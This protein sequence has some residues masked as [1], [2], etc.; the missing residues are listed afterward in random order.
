MPR[1]PRRSRH[2]RGESW[3]ITSTKA[4]EAHKGRAGVTDTEEFIENRFPVS[5]NPNY[6]VKLEGRTVRRNGFRD[7]ILAAWGNQVMKDRSIRFKIASIN[8]PQPYDIYWNVRNT[9]EEAIR[10]NMIR[11]QIRQ[12][13]GSRTRAE[14]T[15]YRGSHYV[16]VYIVKNG[17]VVANDQ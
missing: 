9:G 4:S 6:R 8:V 7:F 5:I 12:D 2:A 3:T 13:D 16:E 11:G 1:A 15:A 17:V 10:A 14:P